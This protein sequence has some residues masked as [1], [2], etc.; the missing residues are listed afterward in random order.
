MH[1]RLT[2]AHKLWTSYKNILQDFTASV[3]KAVCAQISSHWRTHLSLLLYFLLLISR[4]RSRRSSSSSALRIHI[5]QYSAKTFKNFIFTFWGLF[6]LFHTTVNPDTHPLSLASMSLM[7]SSRWLTKD[8]SSW[9]SSC[10]LCCWADDFCQSAEQT[11]T[12]FI[13][14]HV[15]MYTVQ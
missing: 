8:T 12:F 1:K 7:I 6:C 2:C 4:P 11:A 5:W 14:V 15:I 9:R 10:S 13:M 3:V